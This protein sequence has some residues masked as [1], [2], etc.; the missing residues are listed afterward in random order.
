MA[1]DD[2]RAHTTR[3]RVR[4]HHRLAA[5]F[6]PEARGTRQHAASPDAPGYGAAR[7]DSVGC[8]FASRCPV[9]ISTICNTEPP[10]PREPTAGHTIWCHQTAAELSVIQGAERGEA[11]SVLVSP[12]DS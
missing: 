2:L 1:S 9:R 6:R 7:S 8:V 5:A 3:E 11:D 10:P 4:P 12:A